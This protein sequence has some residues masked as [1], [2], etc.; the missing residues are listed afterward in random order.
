MLTPQNGWPCFF[1]T[2]KEN[3]AISKHGCADNY[4]VTS[5]LTF[6]FREKLIQMLF[7]D[8]LDRSHASVPL[9]WCC[10]QTDVKYIWKISKCFKK[11]FK[12]CCLEKKTVGYNIADASS[13]SFSTWVLIYYAYCRQRLVHHSTHEWEWM[14][15]SS[16]VCWF[17]VRRVSQA[18]S[19]RLCSETS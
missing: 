11:Q 19:T 2:L 18:I 15:S 10:L 7:K 5:V 9:I 14:G 13:M 4:I 16:R 17:I 6:T 3:R 1:E 12:N 8:Q